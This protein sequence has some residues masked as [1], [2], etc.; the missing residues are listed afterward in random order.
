MTIA[1]APAA[2]TYGWRSAAD[3]GLDL[4]LG[5]LLGLLIAVVDYAAHDFFPGHQALIRNLIL[6][7][8]TVVGARALETA[9][10]WAIE[11]SRIAAF[12]RAIVYGA[13]GWLGWFT[14]LAVAQIV[15]PREPGGS[16]F[17]SIQFVHALALTAVITVLIGLILHHNRKRSDRLRASI[18]RLKEHEFAEKELEIARAMQKRLLPPPVVEHEGLRVTGRSDAAHIVGGD[19]YDILRLPDGAYAILV[20]DVAGKGIAAS[21][22]VAACK[23]MIPFLASGGSAAEVLSRLNGKLCDQLESREFVSMVLV[24]FDPATGEARVANA[25][26]PDPLRLGAGTAEPIVCEGDRL[27]LGAMRRARY[28]DQKMSLAANERLLLFSDGLP[29]ASVNGNP[30]GYDRFERLAGKGGTVDEIVDRVRALP[31]VLIDDDVTV[32]TIERT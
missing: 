27:P 9:L 8:S 10:S 20:A 23:A 19:F 6:G 21:L 15:V 2:R 17:A 29:E 7:V 11:Q 25:G 32:V 16:D 24:W 26:M 30:I 18:E 12:F 28:I 31:D 5:G 14:G 22:I 3:A 1:A 4:I 13:G